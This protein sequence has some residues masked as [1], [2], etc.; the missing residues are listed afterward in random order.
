[1]SEAEE[2]PRPRYGVHVTI[3]EARFHTLTS[4]ANYA[5]DVLALRPDA[6][7]TITSNDL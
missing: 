7:V 4:A 3:P 6:D 5:A 1:M 2:E